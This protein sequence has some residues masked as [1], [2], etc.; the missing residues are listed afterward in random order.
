MQS[1]MCGAAQLSHEHLALLNGGAAPGVRPEQL[2][3][4]RFHLCVL[5]PQRAYACGLS[6]ASRLHMTTTGKDNLL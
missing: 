5:V 6:V 4:L 2:A 1:G 3:C